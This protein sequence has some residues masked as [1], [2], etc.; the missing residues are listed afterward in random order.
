MYVQLVQALNPLPQP[1]PLLGGGEEKIM[2]RQT[3]E[4]FIAKAKAVWGEEYDYSRTV[5]RGALR[6]VTIICRRHGAFEQLPYNHLGGH[7]CCQC[8]QKTKRLTQ[9]EFVE[10]ARALFP[11]YDYSQVDYQLMHIKVTIVCPVHGPFRRRPAEMLF[12]KLGCPVCCKK[13]RPKRGPD[14]GLAEWQ[15][16][17]VR[18][19]LVERRKAAIAAALAG[20][21]VW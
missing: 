5:Y 4:E 3:T 2:M 16:A 17:L 20:R 8:G 1:L 7:R 14:F 9:A 11:D 13:P 12:K 18:E 10:R 6:A 19:V 15:V 21:G